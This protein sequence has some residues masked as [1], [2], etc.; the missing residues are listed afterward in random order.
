MDI[1][2]AGIEQTE[3]KGHEE[4]TQLISVMLAK[5]RTG[6]EKSVQKS[7][8]ISKRPLAQGIPALRDELFLGSNQ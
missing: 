5:H 4:S 8:Q 6:S 2:Q 3:D 7:H 1:L